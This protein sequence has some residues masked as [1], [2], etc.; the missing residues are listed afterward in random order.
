MKKLIFL[1]IILTGIIGC[2]KDKQERNPNDIH[3]RQ[4][5]TDWGDGQ[6]REYKFKDVA[7]SVGYL[8]M[9]PIENISQ[10]LPN[11]VLENW[12][13]E[14]WIYTSIDDAELA[15]VE[16]LDMSSLFVHN[17]IDYPLPQGQIGDNWRQKQLSVLEPLLKQHLR[18]HYLATR[19]VACLCLKE[20]EWIPSCKADSSAFFIPQTYPFARWSSTVGESS[21]DAWAARQGVISVIKYDTSAIDLLIKDLEGFPELGRTRLGL[22]DGGVA[23]RAKAILK[24][25]SKENW[26]RFEYTSGLGSN[27]KIISANGDFHTVEYRYSFRQADVINPERAKDVLSTFWNQGWNEYAIERLVAV[28]DTFKSINHEKDYKVYLI[29]NVIDNRNYFQDII[30]ILGSIGDSNVVDELKFYL[31]NPELGDI[32]K[33]SMTEIADRS[34]KTQ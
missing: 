32:T 13:I 28:L 5:F 26:N 4:G 2:E 1:I 15:M 10:K 6:I 33:K 34:T 12:N 3:I 21:L 22:M 17:T 31:N 30:E 20:L 9:F 7:E 18:S 19:D 29:D 23:S 24:R 25:L 16:R 14:Y 11:E 27:V 8:T